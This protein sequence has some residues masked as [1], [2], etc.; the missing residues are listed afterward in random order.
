[1]KDQNY[2][3]GDVFRLDEAI[4]RNFCVGKQSLLPKY[5]KLLGPMGKAQKE[6][7]ISK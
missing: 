2:A 5:K 6:G 4:E 7:K 3:V 1:M